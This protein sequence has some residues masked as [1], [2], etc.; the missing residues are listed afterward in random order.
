MAVA[1]CPMCHLAND[2]H[3]WRCER[4][5]Y[6]FGQSIETLRGLLKTQLHNAVAA[7]MI[8]LVIDAAILG[9][10]V[11]CALVLDRVVLPGALFI[12]GLMMTVRFAQKISISRHSLKLI[13]AKEATLPKARLV[14]RS[15]G[16][17][18]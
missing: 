16:G 6:E 13:N 1:R 15:A 12:G 3:A 17:D 18:K 7:V 8:L 9:G 11:Y 2:D 14:D 5:G 4:C 10:T